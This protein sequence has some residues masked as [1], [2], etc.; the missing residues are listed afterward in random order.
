MHE[1]NVNSI[2]CKAC[3]RK[4][5]HTLHMAKYGNIKNKSVDIFNKRQ[6][7]SVT[8]ERARQSMSCID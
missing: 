4:I 6:F 1:N 2:L 7:Y 5:A 3:G 8:Q